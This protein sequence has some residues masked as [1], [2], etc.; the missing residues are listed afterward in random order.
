MR[1][2]K[3]YLNTDKVRLSSSSG[4]TVKERYPLYAI[5]NKKSIAKE[6]MSTRDMN[7]FIKSVTK[8]VEKD[9][10]V[11]YANRNRLSVLEH[12]DLLT[13]VVDTK[14][15]VDEPSIRDLTMTVNVLVTY[16]EYTEMSEIIETECTYSAMTGN[17][18]EDAPLFPDPMLFNDDVLE[19]LRRFGY[20]SQYKLYIGVNL[21]YYEPTAEDDDYSFSAF[22]S[23]RQFAYDELSVFL[24]TYGDTFHVK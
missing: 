13:R 21:P 24:K 17:V 2:W 7:V 1:I 23:G 9:E 3:F 8:D 11:R 6:F 10:W 16:G 19:I 18:M 5:T 4:K 20:P 12:H 15:M 22:G 14:D